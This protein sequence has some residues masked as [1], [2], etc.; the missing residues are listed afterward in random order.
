[1]CARVHVA[2]LR[3][4]TALLLDYNVNDSG[5]NKEST[6]THVTAGCDVAMAI[7]SGFRASENELKLCFK[8]R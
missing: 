4:P 7:A 3:L 8:C 1:M 2:A 6:P 5:S